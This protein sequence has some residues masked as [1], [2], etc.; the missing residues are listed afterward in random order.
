M[1]HD[2]LASRLEPNI[3]DLRDEPNIS[4]SQC[5]RPNQLPKDALDYLNPRKRISYF[6]DAD[7]PHET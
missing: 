2:P 3:I 7:I 4:I 5:L 6:L 1:L